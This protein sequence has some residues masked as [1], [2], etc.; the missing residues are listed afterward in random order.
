MKKTFLSTLVV[1]ISLSALTACQQE[2]STEQP[3]NT[4]VVAEVKEIGRAHV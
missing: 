3:V 1:A 4:E 2:E